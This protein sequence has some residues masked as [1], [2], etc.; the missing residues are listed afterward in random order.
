MRVTS[1]K[2]R[3][4]ATLVEFAL[5]ISVFLMFL[6]G[7]MEYSR[8]LLML[9]VTTNAARD[10]A[11]YASVQVNAPVTLTGT[12]DTTTSPFSSTRPG[13]NVPGITSFVQAEMGGVDGMLSGFT[14]RVYPCDT[15]VLYSDPPVFR[16]KTQPDSTVTPPI[17]T[18]AWNNAQFTER[19][20]VQVTGT[21][22]PIL[23]NFLFMGNS[24][25][26]TIVAVM[27]SEG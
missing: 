8:Y 7:L 13:F 11:R 1:P 4:G 26:V 24:F 19:I 22:T 16:P 12:S 3:R 18:A 17:T 15:S 23:P 5:L 2:R 20:A 9:H 21:Y 14:V 27:G 25:T 6:F 10:G